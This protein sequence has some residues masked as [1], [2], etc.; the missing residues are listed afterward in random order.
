MKTWR[1]IN[2]NMIQ[3]FCKHVW[4]WDR[5]QGVSVL[6]PV[7]SRPWKK[8]NADFSHWMAGEEGEAAPSWPPANED[9]SLPHV[10]PEQ[11]LEMLS[12][13]F[14]LSP[15]FAT[16]SRPLFDEDTPF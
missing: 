15:F 14:V 9:G 11:A 7:P 1:V 16:T 4:L 6:C 12:Q 5:E 3:T 13:E 10:A 2:N 8:V